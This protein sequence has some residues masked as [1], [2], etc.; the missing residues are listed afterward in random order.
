M[1]HQKA[2]WDITNLR[3]WKIAESLE[4]LGFFVSSKFNEAWG[5]GKMAFPF[6][7]FIAGV[8]SWYVM[9]Y[10]I[11]V[12]FLFSKV[13][14]IRTYSSENRLKLVL[15]FHLL[16]IFVLYEQPMFFSDDQDMCILYLLW[17][18]GGQSW[19]SLDNNWGNLAKYNFQPPLAKIKCHQN[20]ITLPRVK[21]FH[22]LILKI[23]KE[24]RLDCDAVIGNKN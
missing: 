19:C 4:N 1:F 7:C 24:I 2:L 18:S 6:L 9:K 11:I 3:E 5:K 21:L 14:S 20:Q 13:T 12:I 17:S 10:E 23:W 22:A 15:L 8:V 16:C